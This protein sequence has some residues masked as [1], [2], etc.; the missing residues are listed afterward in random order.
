MHVNGLTHCSDRAFNLLCLWVLPAGYLVLLS[1]LF[2]LL[3]GSQLH[4]FYYGLFSIPTLIALCLRPGELKIIRGEPLIISFL[5]FACWASLSLIWGPSGIDSIYL[6]KRPLHTFMLFAGCCLLLRHRSESVQPIFLCA[7][8]I[9][10]LASLF[11]LFTFAQSYSAGQRMIGSGA[12]D[13]P[14]LSSHVFGFFCVY[15]LYVSMTTKN[16]QS[17]WFSLAALMVMFAAVLATGSRTPLVALSLAIAW[18]SFICWSRRSLIIIVGLPLVGATLFL[19]YPELVM[20]RGDSYRFELWRLTLDKIAE[21][22]WIG[23]GYSASLSLDP[24]TGFLLS[25]PHNFALGVLFY[26]G[27]LGFAPWLFMLAWGL[28]SSWRQRAKP[29]FILAS[30][31]LAF[32]IGAGLTEGGGILSRPKEHW[33]LLWI[34][35]ALIAALSIASRSRRFP[36]LPIEALAPTAVKRL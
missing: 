19:L 1:G 8:V 24:G 31:W 29:L 7:A 14:L 4:K 2:F 27:I 33:F 11:N 10:L 26:V 28:F 17:L 32:G 18:L 35:L 9:A 30:T 21:S 5:L 15:W 34:P 6:L 3:D 25:E 16:V 23:H 36:P 22:P 20:A 12:F 13:N